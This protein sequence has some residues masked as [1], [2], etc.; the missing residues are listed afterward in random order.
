MQTMRYI[1]L[2]DRTA[3]VKTRK[4][5]VYNN[6]IFFAV[7]R[8]FVSKAIGPDA[9]NIRKIQESLG[10]KIKVI[11]EAGGY[12][13]AENFVEDVVSPAKFKSFEVKDGAGII[14]AGN[15]QNKAILI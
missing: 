5:F 4:C 12:E 2:L 6:T 11:K 9:S 3:H 7:P 14:T 1:N 15:N 8:Q 10:K 13:D